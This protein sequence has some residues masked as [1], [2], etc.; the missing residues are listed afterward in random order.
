MAISTESISWIVERDILSE[1]G[2]RRTRAILAI[3]MARRCAGV[4]DFFVPPQIAARFSLSPRDLSWAL[5]SLDGQLVETVGATK[6]KFRRLRLLPAWEERAAA[7]NKTAKPAATT[8]KGNRA[9]PDRKAQPA[10]GYTPAVLDP[11]V[12]LTLQEIARE[13]IAKSAPRPLE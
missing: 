13:Q 6:G 11:A 9:V 12:E 2:D 8:A 3:L 5:R 7:S 1:L 4:R 10:G